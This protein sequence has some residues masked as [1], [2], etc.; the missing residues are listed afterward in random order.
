VSS[1]YSQPSS[2]DTLTATLGDDKVDLMMPQ[3]NLRF[4]PLT[5]ALERG[6]TT[7]GAFFDDEDYMDRVDSL[8]REWQG[9]RAK[10]PRAK[11][12]ADMYPEM[13][14]LF[15]HL[16]LEKTLEIEAKK[17]EIAR[18]LSKPTESLVA[19]LSRDVILEQGLVADIMRLEKEIRWFR[20]GLIVDSVNQNG[21][22]EEQIQ[23]AR[24]FP[25]EDLIDTKKVNKMWCCPF[26]EERSPSFHIYKENSWHCFGC[27]AHGN[28]AI[29]FVMKKNKLEF[30]DA[31]KFLIGK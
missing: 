24:D 7:S 12:W 28:N 2:F 1:K 21:L 18:I 23:Q 10:Q 19:E 30:V 27:Q 16:I 22:T 5:K 4:S 25:V 29:D 20:L 17:L 26:H 31:V 6:I 15:N 14:S 13:R 3:N 11:E 9:G 8:R